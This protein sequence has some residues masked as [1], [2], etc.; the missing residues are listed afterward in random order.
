[1]TKIP[2]NP[3][4]SQILITLLTMGLLFKVSRMRLIDLMLNNSFMF[5][6]T[7]VIF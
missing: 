2:S 5:M 1:M 4:D 3:N 6:N 7:H